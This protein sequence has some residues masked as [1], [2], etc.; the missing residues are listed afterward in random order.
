ME[1]LILLITEFIII[2]G[3][4]VRATDGNYW[5]ITLIKKKMVIYPSIWRIVHYYCCPQFLQKIIYIYIK[6]K[7]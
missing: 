7:S 3:E 6:F 1:L 4:G 2:G 5:V